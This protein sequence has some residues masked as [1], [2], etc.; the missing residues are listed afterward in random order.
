MTELQRI[1]YLASFLATSCLAAPAAEAQDWPMW[2]GDATRNM[3]S[4]VTD[5]P[6]N[7]G[8]SQVPEEPHGTGCAE[9]APVGTSFLR[10]NTQGSP[11]PPGNPH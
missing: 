7:F 8:W 5:L 1:I 10:R 6:G 3:V 2:G 9:R 11:P 4:E